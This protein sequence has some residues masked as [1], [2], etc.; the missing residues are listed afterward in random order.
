[1]WVEHD[2]KGVQS[3]PPCPRV[4]FLGN[5][6][7]LAKPYNGEN[8]WRDDCV[9]RPESPPYQVGSLDTV[10]KKSIENVTI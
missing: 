1:L 2:V 10:P 4:Y 5:G 8:A 7:L 3:G 6:G 9:W